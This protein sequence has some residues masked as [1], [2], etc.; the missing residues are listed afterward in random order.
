MSVRFVYSD[1]DLGVLRMKLLG[2]LL[3]KPHLQN[4]GK[5]SM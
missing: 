2:H 4:L 3:S 5:T 1:S